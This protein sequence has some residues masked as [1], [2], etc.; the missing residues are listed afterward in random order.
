MTVIADGVEQI[1]ALTGTDLGRSPWLEV[2]QDRVDTFADATG[3]RQWIHVDP[4]RAANGPFGGTIAHGY[5]TLAL[6]IPMFTELL[7]VRG[8]SMSVNY[9][10]ERVRFPAPV[11]VGS[12]I[13][14]AARVD[15]VEEVSNGV[16]MTLDF[17]VE[18][19]GVDKPA[20]VARPIY[21]HYV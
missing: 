13:R 19:D 15:Q 16:Q 5:L 21:R 17:T 4:V 7:E 18:I 1:K 12:K 11:R 10:L 14:L 20:C 6:V 9:G 8:M 3:D 2:T